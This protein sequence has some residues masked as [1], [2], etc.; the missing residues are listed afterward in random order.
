MLNVAIKDV[1]LA[2]KIRDLL[3][4]EVEAKRMALATLIGAR[5][6]VAA[7]RAL[8]NA[9]QLVEKNPALLRLRELD[10][11]RSFA[12]NSN[13]TVVMGVREGAPL[14][15]KNGNSGDLSESE[16]SQDEDAA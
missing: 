4:K 15:R 10:V 8:A 12:A 5:E 7:L 14:I 3:L 6:E 9:A 11:A 13:N 1:M 16:S 2:P